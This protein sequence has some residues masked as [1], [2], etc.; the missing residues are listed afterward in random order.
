[1]KN[2]IIQLVIVAI[3]GAIAIPGMYIYYFGSCND[4]AKAWFIQTAPKRCVLL[5]AE[6]NE[7]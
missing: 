4:I 7:K 6:S 3:L 1:M 2:I 5:S